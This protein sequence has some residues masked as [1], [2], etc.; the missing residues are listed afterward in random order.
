MPIETFKYRWPTWWG[1]ENWSN[2]APEIATAGQKVRK[3]IGGLQAKKQAGGP[4]FAVKSGKELMFKLRDALDDLGYDAPVVESTGGDIPSEKGTCAFLTVTVELQCPD[5]S[6]KRFKGSGHGADRDDKAGGKASTY[7]W[8]DALVK[9]LSLPDA[10]M[11][12]SDDEA[13]VS[14]QRPPPGAKKATAQFDP[15]DGSDQFKTMYAA[16]DGLDKDGIKTL[17]ADAKKVLK[18]P[19]LRAFAD[20]SIPL[21]GGK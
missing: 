1:G 13:G 16:L 7:A 2:E 5:G 20:K 8:K 15:A 4:Q 14:P 18:G 9:G 6:F 17:I 12:D 21:L 19:E 11:A 10:E 3:L